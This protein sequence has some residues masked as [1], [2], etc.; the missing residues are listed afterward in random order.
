MKVVH[1]D[2]AQHAVLG[3]QTVAQFKI[4]THS[5]ELFRL[6]SDTLYQNKPLAVVREVLCNAWDAHIM[7]G[8]QGTPVQVTLTH[9]DLIIKDFGPGI[10]DSK[11]VEVYCTLMATTKEEL[12]NQTG[13]FGLGSKAPFAYTDFFTVISRHAGVQ[14]IYAVSRGSMESG[15]VPEI[16]LMSQGPTEE[17]GLEVQVPVKGKSDYF[18][19]REHVLNVARDGA[20]NVMLND[21]PVPAY[22]YG[23]GERLGYVLRP[24]SSMSFSVRYGAV[25]YP[26]NETI[27]EIKVEIERIRE[28]LTG[29]GGHLI[30]M[31]KPNSVGIT[32]SRESLSYE[33]TTITH[34]SGLLR[35]F[36]HEVL[37]QHRKALERCADELALADMEKCIVENKF[38]KFDGTVPEMLTS[39]F[40]IAYYWARER[41]AHGR[42]ELVTRAIVKRWL[43]DMP[44]LSHVVMDRNSDWAEVI[45]GLSEAMRKTIPKVVAKT[46]I[47]CRL[48]AVGGFVFTP[49]RR[50]F[51]GRLTPRTVY[52]AERQID[53]K[54][55]VDL[56]KETKH[57]M[58]GCIL[59][60]KLNADHI[61]RLKAAFKPY[62]ITVKSFSRIVVEKKPVEQK[63]EE[64]MT[65]ALSFA[66]DSGYDSRSRF[67]I[68]KKGDP[69]AFSVYMSVSH[70]AN[71]IK[72]DEPRQLETLQELLAIMPPTGVALVSTKTDLKRAEAAGAVE[73]GFYARR[74]ISAHAD[75]PDFKWGFIRAQISHRL[76]RSNSGAL[77]TWWRYSPASMAKLIGITGKPKADE[78]MMLLGKTAQKWAVSYKEEGI[79]ARLKD[80]DHTKTLA[81]LGKVEKAVG[82]D[83]LS[84]LGS[85][86]PELAKQIV[87]LVLKRNEDWI[88]EGL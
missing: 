76:Y 74:E 14:S 36:R 83:V 75:D 6:L 86:E 34:L 37:S 7:V 50:T 69:T 87:R 60:P 54:E 23:D 56:G 82:F 11:M 77:D 48:N 65:V 18:T 40:D 79:A 25:I 51:K 10:A 35:K 67:K 38:P 80:V 13:G 59:V 17:S 49:L 88:K 72:I 42:D 85:T 52:V 20:M 8:N 29:L 55:A 58:I 1:V 26:L 27:P 5:A 53:V 15:G 78:R 47:D 4:T 66:R 63:V 43:R 21:K 46:G 73:I 28:R 84:S 81:L 44:M 19:F 33:P 32:P 16:R 45:S 64:P 12:A 9:D 61:A 68:T 71:G 22:D 31:A 3:G 24:A 62:G 39:A 41:I 2:H 70:T 30:L 57:H